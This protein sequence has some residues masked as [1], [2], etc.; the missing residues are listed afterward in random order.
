VD[1][2]RLLIWR[3]IQIFYFCDHFDELRQ[4]NDTWEPWKHGDQSI[5]CVSDDGVHASWEPGILVDANLSAC[6]DNTLDITIPLDLTGHILGLADQRLE[7]LTTGKD[8]L[9]RAV[10]SARSVSI[11]NVPERLFVYFN[12]A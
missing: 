2:F 7:I 9:T 12:L 10:D 11:P 5:V 4:T 8:T 1:F 3:G 6:V